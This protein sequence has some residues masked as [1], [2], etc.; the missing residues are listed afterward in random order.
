MLNVL[1]ADL[2]KLAHLKSFYVVAILAAFFDF[3]IL[4]DLSNYPDSYRSTYDHFLQAAFDPFAVWQFMPMIVP[5]AL[6]IVIC[7]LVTNDFAYGTMR[8]P[9][10]LG[11]SRFHVFFSKCVAAS[12]ASVV[13]LLL[14]TL[15]SVFIALSMLDGFHDEPAFR[16]IIQFGA[17]T[18]LVIGLSIA[19]AVLF[20][21][22]AFVVRH[23]AIVM[24]I[25]FCVALFV[26]V[27]VA[28]VFSPGSPVF[29]AWPATAMVAVNGPLRVEMATAVLAV[30]VAY[31]LV[32]FAIGYGV[33][34]KR[35]MK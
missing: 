24:A 31:L 17:R 8:D 7:L 2:Y 23:T 21:T 15:V 27:I 9:V 14:C 12:T 26:T 33:F 32:S 16:D 3:F 1:R 4:F 5:L 29:N 35:D 13:I 28:S 25:H 10:T 22:I 30:T 19:L 18:L 20:T 11:H 34:A 6:G